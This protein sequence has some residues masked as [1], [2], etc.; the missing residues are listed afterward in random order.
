MSDP[1]NDLI[2]PN[3]HYQC[4]NLVGCEQ[5]TS[6]LLHIQFPSVRNASEHYNYI[7]L[8]GAHKSC[9]FY[10]TSHELVARDLI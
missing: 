4:G 3:S 8:R 2:C 5:T 9:P 7:C 10:G 1:R 6:I